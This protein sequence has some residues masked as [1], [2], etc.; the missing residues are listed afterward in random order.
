MKKI[1][2]IILLTLLLQ[3]QT[4]ATILPES[5]AI[6]V[7]P[8]QLIDADDF[9]I[10][11]QVKFV[12]IQPV[13]INKETIIPAGTEVISQVIQKKNN[14]IL[15]I[16][17]KIEIGNFHILTK[18]NEIIRLRGTVEDKGDSKYWVHVGWFFLFP[19][20]FIKGNDGKIQTNTTQ[21]LYTIEEIDL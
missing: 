6:I 16:P 11:S 4:N 19:I 15:G 18:D 7:Q 8:K 5:T 21:I 14:F 3:I 20:L 10:G 2:S 9:K 13:K 1:V 17:G 12:V